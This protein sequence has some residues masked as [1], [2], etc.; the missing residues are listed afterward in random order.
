MSKRVFIT[1]DRLGQG[2]DEL[3]SVLMKNFLYTLARQEVPPAAVM[4]M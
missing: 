1:T 4:L 3:G 2:S